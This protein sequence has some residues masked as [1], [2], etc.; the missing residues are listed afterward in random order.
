MLAL[1]STEYCRSLLKTFAHTIVATSLCIVVG[2]AEYI[3][4]AEVKLLSN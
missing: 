2:T 3:Q 1:F 4:Y